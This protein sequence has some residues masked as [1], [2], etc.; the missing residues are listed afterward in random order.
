MKLA[1]C[2][3][4]FFISVNIIRLND[5]VVE[6]KTGGVFTSE[7]LSIYPNGNDMSAQINAVAKLSFVEAIRFVSD[8]AHAFI[9]NAA[10]DF[11][12]TRVIFEN[13]SRLAGTGTIN[14]LNYEASDY[15][16]IFDTTLNF[17]NLRSAKGYFSVNSF[18]GPVDTTVDIG[19]YIKKG[20]E[21]VTKNHLPLKI[22]KGK[23]YVGVSVYFQTGLK[24]LG[25]GI[26]Q[27]VL[28]IK[29]GAQFMNV[30]TAV[31]NVELNGM[32]F[33]MK[34]KGRGSN[35]IQ[36]STTTDNDFSTNIWL[37]SLKLK[38]HRKGNFSIFFGK[39][40]NGGG[41]NIS[42][43]SSF[44]GALRTTT[45]KDIKWDSIVVTNAG[46]SGIG[47]GKDVNGYVLTNFVVDGFAQ[48]LPFTDG[49]IDSYGP[50]NSNFY[51]S[52][53]VVKTGRTTYLNAIQHILIRDQGNH[54]GT[55]EN[56][57]LHAQ[58]KLLYGI[59]NSNRDADYTYGVQF[60]NITLNIDSG[61]TYDKLIITQNALDADF[62][63][64][65]IIDSNAV[66]RTANAY[67][68]NIQRPS[69][70]DTMNAFKFAGTIVLNGSNA[71]L[72]NWLTPTRKIDLSGTKIYGL[73]NIAYRTSLAVQVNLFKWHDG[74]IR[75]S[76]NVPLFFRLNSVSVFDIQG[77]FVEKPDDKL[78]DS[79]SSYS[80]LI[81]PGYNSING[82]LVH[83]VG[84]TIGR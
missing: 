13:G 44:N 49:G 26:D 60:K 62:E 68:L 80:G 29:P 20:I 33:E 14:N 30:D 43:D 27:T 3:L 66:A 39:V 46:R 72:M 37:N 56:I 59:R 57:V 65:V 74:Y 2:I 84:D 79:T 42:I 58:G 31:H 45:S 34:G 35:F 76:I 77:V 25:D 23:Y 82:K 52:N 53:G 11:K 51:V 36:F 15:N 32:T 18:T 21:V 8:S 12:N 83:S 55:Y 7:E 78:W 67:V 16:K 9:I 48:N 71:R 6:L 81:V 61:A 50:N 22:P 38:M 24:L 64:N 75:T 10:V 73:N 4:F 54:N 1:F 70:L 5:I 28:F 69:V 19:D 17:S 41:R 63:V 47:I 40:K